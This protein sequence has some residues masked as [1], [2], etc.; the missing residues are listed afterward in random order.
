VALPPPTTATTTTMGHTFPPTQP[1][2]L[3]VRG[4]AFFNATCQMVNA[5]INATRSKSYAL[6]AA[7]FQSA[8]FHGED[9]EAGGVNCLSFRATQL[10]RKSYFTKHFF[11]TSALLQKLWE[12]LVSEQ[13]DAML[14]I[15]NPSMD[16]FSTEAFN[17]VEDLRYVLGTQTLNAALPGLGFTTFSATSVVMDIIEATSKKL[18]IAFFSCVMVCFILIAISFGAALI[19]FKLLFTVVLPISWSYGAALYVYEDGVFAWTGFEGLQPMKDAGIDWTVPIFTLTIM[20]GLA[21]DYDVFLFER[22]FEFRAEGF[23]DREAIQLGLSAT[24][25]IISAAGLIFAF[26]F[27]SLLLASMPVNNQIGFVFIFSI[28][29]DTFIVRTVLVPCMLSLNPCLNYWP[30]KMPAPDPRLNWLD[31]SDSDDYDSE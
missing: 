11:F 10:Y 14:T 7:D 26:T 23:G 5:L 16:P 27:L 20:L 30:T 3:D 17:L 2:P 13:K 6:R 9:T 29:V 31:G 19:P 4:Q 12:Q 24:G 8:T 28:V 25:P 22:V 1:P 18:P 21:L 15:L